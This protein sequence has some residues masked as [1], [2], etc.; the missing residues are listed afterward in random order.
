MSNETANV[1][2]ILMP[3]TFYSEE[4]GTGEAYTATQDNPD[5]S[6]I[7]LA[8][9]FSSVTLPP[10]TK[11]VMYSGANYTGKTLAVG[12][13]S[14]EI[15]TVDFSEDIGWIPD[16]PQLNFSWSGINMNDQCRSFKLYGEIQETS[17]SSFFEFDLEYTGNGVEPTYI[18]DYLYGAQYLTYF[19][20]NDSSFGPEHNDKA[21]SALV[22]SD[23]TADFYEDKAWGGR[24]TGFNGSGVTGK[25]RIYNFDGY[26]SWLNNIASSIKVGY[27]A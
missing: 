5:L 4:Q 12:N 9:T 26:I 27:L 19:N 16:D 24:V 6:T 21:S 3:V 17:L 13:G 23:R 20:E 14:L 15:I 25:A 18:Y 8:N 10:Q 11:V 2:D 7:G 1:N 22:F